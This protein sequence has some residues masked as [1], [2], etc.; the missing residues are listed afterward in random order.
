MRGH[1]AL[2][3]VVE[4]CAITVLANAASTALTSTTHDHTRRCHC[5]KESLASTVNECQVIGNSG[6]EGAVMAQTCTRSCTRMMPTSSEDGAHASKVYQHQQHAAPPARTRRSE[7]HEG[8]HSSRTAH[9][10]E[11]GPKCKLA[12]T[13]TEFAF[14]VPSTDSGRA[15]RSA[16]LRS[17]SSNLIKRYTPLHTGAGSLYFSGSCSSSVN[18]SK[19]STSQSRQHR[20]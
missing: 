11:P 17:R 14:W 12:Q 19:A 8:T 4:V 15:R 16:F 2:V 7:M 13:L 10:I 5:L 3:S 9:A 18:K 1:A 6:C 20:L